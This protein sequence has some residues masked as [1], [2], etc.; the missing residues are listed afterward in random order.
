MILLDTHVLLWLRAADARLGRR[1]LD[2]IDRA[3]HADAL[4]PH[5]GERCG[6]VGRLQPDDVGKIAAAVIH[7]EV[8]EAVRTLAN[9][10]NPKHPV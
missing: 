8:D 5:I 2:E 4:A 1:A 7:G 3:W 6:S 10:A 9:V